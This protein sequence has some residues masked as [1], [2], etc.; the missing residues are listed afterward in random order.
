MRHAVSL[1]SRLTLC[2]LGCAVQ[3]AVPRVAVWDPQVS[4][5]QS[6]FTVDKDYLDDVAGWLTAADVGVERLTA[7][8]IA[9]PARF[10]AGRFD[11]LFVQGGAVPAD[12]VDAYVRFLDAGGIL[13][14]LASP[15]LFEIKIA[16]DAAGAWKLSPEE[17]RFAW[18]TDAVH[19]ALGMQFRSETAMAQAGVRHTPSPLLR[20]YLP[21]ASEVLRPLTARWFTPTN[22][23]FHPLVR[24][25]LASGEDYTPQVFLCVSGARRAILC[26]S[27]FWTAGPDTDQTLGVG[28]QFR[29]S[30]FRPGGAGSEVGEWPHGRAMVVAFARLAA[31]LR[32]GT[33]D[34]DGASA[35]TP[36]EAVVAPAPL[37]SRGL[38]TG[39]A[40]EGARALARWGRFDGSRLELGADAAPGSRTR[41]A[42]SGAARAVPGGLPSGAS[43]A[44]ALPA[45]PS[46]APLYVRLR[47]AVTNSATHVRLAV[48]D[49]VLWHEELVLRSAGD[50][51]AD[52]PLEVTRIVFVPPGTATQ[53]ELVLA[54]PGVGT[55]FL[56]A[57]QFETPTRPARTVEL[58]LH[59]STALAYDGA[60]HGLTAEACRDWS[61]L[62]CT[63]RPWWIGPPDATDRWDRFDKH[64]ERYLA[65]HP[66]P[67]FI[68]E[69]T[70]EWAAISPE[71]YAAGGKRA[72]MAPP[73]NA[74]YAELAERI[75][76]KFAARVQDWEIWNEASVHGFWN[77]TPG[78]F[79]ELH[80]AVAPIIRRLD[81][82]ARIITA[83]MA[84]VTRGTI[85]PFALAMSRSGALAPAQADL[86]AVHCY[87]PN[88]MWDLPYGLLDG[89]LM[90]L[91]ED[92]EIYANEQG[93]ELSGSV[94]M[95]DQA[96]QNDRGMARLLA[97]GVAKIV[98]FQSDSTAR[99]SAFGVLDERGTPRPAY[100]SFLD[101]LELTR[102]GGRRL[103]VSMTAPGG[104]ALKGVYVA[105]ARHADGSVTL[106]INPADHDAFLPPPSPPD[107]EF[108]AV[109]A[110]RWSCFWG[111]T[112]W[113]DG[114]VTV[115]YDGQHPQAGFFRKLRI[116][117]VRNPE[118]EISV[119]DTTARWQLLL[120]HGDNQAIPL[121]DSTEPGIFRKRF[122][123][124]L[125]SPSTQEVEVSIRASRKTTFDYVRFPVDASAAASAASAVVP[126]LVRLPLPDTAA[127]R[128][129]AHHGEEAQA[130]TITVFDK[131]TPRWAEI[132]TV[133][134]GR[135]VLRVLPAAR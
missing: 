30:G 62:R 91:G 20:A 70:P 40:P 108:D 11:A 6:R 46:D 61:V 24:S 119:K 26:S 77:G 131:G 112:E 105:A 16:Q 115:T 135:T 134:K 78:E 125:P 12:N 104:A 65:L 73:D 29:S 5:V 28:G 132:E 54:N 50:R 47:C 109:H 103:D 128:V 83:G 97:S 120:K 44:F 57:L 64:I 60:R 90:A 106:V 13:V 102:N 126:V 38:A 27:G 74:K 111:S 39:I 122:A 123:D 43:I 3:G 107:E 51:Y 72:H 52:A 85:D 95:E 59:T 98:I 96:L 113:K 127:W 35:V 9:D 68:F 63:M 79:T 67:Q 23:V 118:I 7:A 14:A 18:Q 49:T 8:Q 66:R 42:A 114:R 45:L 124:A 101:Y 71:R 87:A 116:D 69:G 32:A 88:G 75:V 89:H 48:G 133:V 2:L 55:L 129:E 36:V 130:A 4:T 41:V 53:G 34:L 99:S 10:D 82:S 22:A 86:F 93:T 31:D 80:K 58:G 25:Q 94:D 21:E 92:L 15:N 121:F 100:A 76:G 19:S 56:D 84:G 1:L 117:P 17:P 81:P 110:K 33:V 37:A